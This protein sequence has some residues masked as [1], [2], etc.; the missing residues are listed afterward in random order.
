MVCGKLNV[1]NVTK[2][3]Q[4]GCLETKEGPL[5]DKMTG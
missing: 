4:Y 5:R 3:I 1:M 2:E